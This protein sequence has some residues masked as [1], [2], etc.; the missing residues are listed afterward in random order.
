[1]ASPAPIPAGRPPTCT[2]RPTANAWEMHS[3]HV[4]P[5]QPQQA[6]PAEP[7][8]APNPERLARVAQVATEQATIAARE[9]AVASLLERAAA[10]ASRYASQLATIGQKAAEFDAARTAQLAIDRAGLGR[11]VAQVDRLR[12]TADAMEQDAQH[13]GLLHRGQARRGAA[14]ARQTAQDAEQ[15]FRTEWGQDRGL[16]TAP[17]AVE[18]IAQAR[19]GIWRYRINVAKRDTD[20]IRAQARGRI[21]A[22]LGDLHPTWIDRYGN[23][24]ERIVRPDEPDHAF[25]RLE[26]AAADLRESS[27]ERAKLAADLEAASPQ[28]RIDWLTQ[29]EAA[30]ARASEYWERVQPP[31]H[32]VRPEDE[33]HHRGPDRGITPGLS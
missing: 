28:E 15:A 18:R 11:A 3:T 6:A 25:G 29:R 16:D 1:M 22:A 30:A 17:Q 31:A 26:R 27:S 14:D 23:D 4:P 2:P 24:L 21:L 9:A 12:R 19:T 32:R 7:V 8:P 13:A 33:Y 20:N 10:V 5:V